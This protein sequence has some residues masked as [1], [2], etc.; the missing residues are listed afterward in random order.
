VVTACE[1][2]MPDPAFCTVCFPP[3][4]GPPVPPRPGVRVEV[5]LEKPGQPNPPPSEPSFEGLSMASDPQATDR[6]IEAYLDDR[7]PKGPKFLRAGDFDGL[8]SRTYTVIGFSVFRYG[9][10]QPVLLLKDNENDNLGLVVKKRQAKQLKELGVKGFAELQWSSIVLSVETVPGFNRQDTPSFLIE[11]IQPGVDPDE[12]GAR[13]DR[14]RV[15]KE[16]W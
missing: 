4:F 5:E 16:D 2:G 6:S 1:H 12:A 8:G 13:V 11:S 14:K 15:T 9:D 3:D 7:A 10:I